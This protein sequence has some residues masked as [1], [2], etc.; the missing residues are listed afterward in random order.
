MIGIN[1]RN[2]KTFQTDPAVTIRLAPGIPQGVLVVSESG[3]A[4]PDDLHRM[5]DAGITTFLI[6][7]SLMR[8]DDLVA[9]TQALLA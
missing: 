3:L 7:E 9:A 2:L 5:A 8:A 4:T 1:N 6:G